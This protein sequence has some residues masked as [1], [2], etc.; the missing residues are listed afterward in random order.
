[1]STLTSPD[2]QKSNTTG[3]RALA[4]ALVEG[5]VSVYE[6]PELAAEQAASGAAW[7]EQFDA[8]QVARLFLK[9]VA[10]T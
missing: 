9:A 3:L 5:I 4:A 8:P 10:P 6:E 2:A 1:M 7:V